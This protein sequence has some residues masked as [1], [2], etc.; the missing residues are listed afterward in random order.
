MERYR[1]EFTEIVRKTVVL[2]AESEEAAEEIIESGAYEEG[3]GLIMSEITEGNEFDA[4]G[5]IKV[6]I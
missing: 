2:F 4:I 5:G 3:G 6:L 1:I